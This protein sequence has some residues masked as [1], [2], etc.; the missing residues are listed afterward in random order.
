MINRIKNGFRFLHYWIKDIFF[1][2]FFTLD[3]VEIEDQNSAQDQFVELLQL[4][5]RIIALMNQV[6]ATTLIENHPEID[7]HIVTFALFRNS[8]VIPVPNDAIKQRL[9]KIGDVINERLDKQ[10]LRCH[11]VKIVMTEWND[12]VTLDAFDNEERVTIEFVVDAGIVPAVKPSEYLEEINS[13]AP[14]K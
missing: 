14:N 13:L 3:F 12:R 9:I 11:G 1:C 8:K 2:N 6:H 4:G 7:S 10:N 5:D